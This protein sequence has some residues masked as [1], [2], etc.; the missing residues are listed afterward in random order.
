MYINE[1]PIITSG[2]EFSADENQLSIGTITATDPEE[3][4]L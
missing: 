4:P 2:P 3:D 1:A